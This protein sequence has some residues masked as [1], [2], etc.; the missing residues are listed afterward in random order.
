[1]VSLL[2]KQYDDDKKEKDYMMISA[3]CIL[4]TSKKIAEQV[5]FPKTKQRKGSAKFE[6]VV[7]LSNLNSNLKV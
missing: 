2:K 4:K 1:M 3:S 6:L 5:L 7:K